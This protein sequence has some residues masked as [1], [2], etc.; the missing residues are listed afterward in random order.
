M[1]F[2][3]ALSDAEKGADLATLLARPDLLTCA[4][5]TGSDGDSITS[6]AHV[7]DSGSE[8]R[9]YTPTNS[10]SGGSTALTADE[11]HT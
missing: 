9:T 2:S 1:H 8:G 11:A 7:A 3:A 6:T 10:P 5:P 4:Q